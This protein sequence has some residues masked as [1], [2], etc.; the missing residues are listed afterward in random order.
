MDDRIQL[1]VK[2]EIKKLFDEISSEF[3]KPADALAML[4]E[5]YLALK[6]MEKYPN[7]KDNYEKFKSSS[8]IF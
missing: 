6:A 2:K 3:E 8:K 7:H 4:M 1:R 5:N